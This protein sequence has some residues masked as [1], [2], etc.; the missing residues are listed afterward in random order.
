VGEVWRERESGVCCV[1][2]RGGGP[3]LN[4]SVS[5]GVHDDDDGLGLQCPPPKDVCFPLLTHH[6]PQPPSHLAQHLV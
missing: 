3:W 5:R 2:R 4:S 6:T 1:L